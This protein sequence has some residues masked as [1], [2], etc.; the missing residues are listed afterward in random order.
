MWHT[1]TNECPQ[2]PSRFRLR[3]VVCSPIPGREWLN[4]CV[5]LNSR[6]S[7]TRLPQMREY[8]FPE[9]NKILIENSTIPG[10][11]LVRL[12]THTDHRGHLTEIFRASWFEDCPPFVQWNMVRSHANSLRGVH[13]HL[14]HLDLLF[15][16]SG[17][18]TLGLKD[19][20][21]N[22]PAFLREERH[23][24]N[25]SPITGVLTPPGVAHGF[26]HPETT[27]FVYGVTHYF[28][29]DDELGFRWN[30]AD[31]N[32]FDRSL[33][34]LISPR[35]TSAGSLAQL[36]HRLEPHQSEFSVGA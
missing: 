28:A 13:V 22:S 10:V 32:L 24:L 6:Y 19:L 33:T 30:D 27:I 11:R 4:G 1:R 7:V 31:C 14:R 12:Q 23:E 36:L 8:M 2:F 18:M 17:R 21:R 25:E 15:L 5:P 29:M 26:Y 34:P 35:D 16:I 3:F 9:A 20:R